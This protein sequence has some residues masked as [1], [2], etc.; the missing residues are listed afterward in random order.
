MALCAFAATFGA[1]AFGV[2][3]EEEQTPLVVLMYHQLLHSRKSDYIVSPERFE[4][5]LILL[6]EKGYACVTTRQIVD[7]VLYEGDL[8]EKPVLITFDDG[9]YNNLYYGAKILK[10]QGF[11]ALVSVIGR[12]CENATNLGTGGNP[13]YSYLTWDE[14]K[15]MA[16]SELFEIG[17]HTYDMHNYQPRF[18]VKQ[19]A[20]ESDA[21][22][23]KALKND[24]GKLRDKLDEKCGVQCSA[25]AYPFGA[26]NELTKKIFAEEGFELMLTCNEGVSALK[27]GERACLYRI[28]RYNR[29][30]SF[31]LARILQ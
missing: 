31:D 29:S 13:N 30:P 17:S 15:L 19:K 4:R 14:V 25:F 2:S 12:F 3:A 8:P 16:E 23:V 11:T 6:K 21:E 7:Y 27:R 28:K 20:G 24:I 18:G 1:R 10:E 9:H 5:D 22:Y 26:Y